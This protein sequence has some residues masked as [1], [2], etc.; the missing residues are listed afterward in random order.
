MQRGRWSTSDTGRTSAS[1]VA[2][3]LTGT[4]QGERTE[5]V[6]L[7]EADS[8]YRHLRARDSWSRLDGPNE[9]QELARP[10]TVCCDDRQRFD[11]PSPSTSMVAAR[12]SC[13]RWRRADS[14]NG[15]SPRTIGPRQSPSARWCDRV[16]AFAATELL[17]RVARALDRA[18]SLCAA[19]STDL[20]SRGVVAKLDDH[21]GRGPNL[22]VTESTAV[23]SV[24]CC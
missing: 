12:S 6:Q 8:L 9:V 22:P 16:D 4:T 2:V 13:P 5:R 7:D 17:R 21:V 10:A 15:R 23:G 11:R 18:T 20:A 14:V 1:S 3:D 24:K 19:P